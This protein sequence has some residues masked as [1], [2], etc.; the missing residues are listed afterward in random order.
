VITLQQSA[1]QFEP[2]A[3]GELSQAKLITLINE[4]STQ[5]ELEVLPPAAGELV[6]DTSQAVLKMKPAT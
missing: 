2:R 5:L 3:T 6:L 4:S 1:V